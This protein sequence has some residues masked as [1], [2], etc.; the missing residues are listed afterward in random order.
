VWEE[1]PQLAWRLPIAAG[2]L[3]SVPF[4]NSTSLA[5]R[6]NRWTVVEAALLAALAVV[7]WWPGWS[8]RRS[9]SASGS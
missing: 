5:I 3:I 6:L 7:A 1:K 8:V 4:V 9:A 2:W